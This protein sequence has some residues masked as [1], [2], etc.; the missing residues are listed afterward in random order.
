MEVSD[1]AQALRFHRK[2]AGLSQKDLA[3]LASVGK[4]VI[5]D[6]EK[7]KESVQLDTLLKVLNALN[8]H[9]VF[10]G[11]MMHTFLRSKQQ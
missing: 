3:K 11:P 1:L 7:A 6:L 10:Q 8:I 2:K 5:Y 9:M 4:T